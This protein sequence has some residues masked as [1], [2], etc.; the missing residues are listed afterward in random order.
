MIPKILFTNFTNPQRDWFWLS[1]WPRFIFILDAAALV[2]VDQLMKAGLR[3]NSAFLIFVLIFLLGGIF[4][5][6]VATEA[7]R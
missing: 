6:L 7:E 5:H 2:I 1:I 4:H 3:E